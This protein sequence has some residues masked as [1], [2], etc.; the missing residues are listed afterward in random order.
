[1][2]RYAVLSCGTD[3]VPAFLFGTGKA[4][5]GDLNGMFKDFNGIE[6]IEQFGFADEGQAEAGRDLHFRGWPMSG[7]Q[8]ADFP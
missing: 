6:R 4:M 1:M 8:R 3:A 5:V 7:G 2:N